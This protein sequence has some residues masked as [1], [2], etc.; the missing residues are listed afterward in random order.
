MTTAVTRPHTVTARITTPDTPP[1]MFTATV[2]MNTARRHSF[3]DYQ[4]GHPLAEAT[5]PDGSP[6]RLVFHTSDRITDHEAAAA[7]DAAFAVGNRQRPDDNGQTWPTDIRF[8]SVGDVIKVT[9][10]DHW[11]VYLSVDH[12][13]FSA[14][15]EPTNLTGLAGTR[16]TNRR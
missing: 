12:L 11:I 2:F 15:P 1:A 6:L 9:G 10:P 4:P 13:S 8:V 14:V 3:D 16:A 5:R 7:A